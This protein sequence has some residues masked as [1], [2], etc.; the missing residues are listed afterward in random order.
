VNAYFEDATGRRFDLDLIGDIE[1]R[2]PEP[3][4][5]LSRGSVS[6]PLE[7]TFSIPIRVGLGKPGSPSLLDVLTAGGAEPLDGDHLV[8]Q[9]VADE[10][11]IGST[12]GDRIVQAR[13]QSGY[14]LTARWSPKTL[15]QRRE[16]A[17][18]RVAAEKREKRRKFVALRRRIRRQKHGWR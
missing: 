1:F 7:G 10:F 16:E 2:P 3:E 13:T 11:R 9:F 8:K 17:Y 4:V 14:T 6:S 15:A 5:N 18:Q 12:D